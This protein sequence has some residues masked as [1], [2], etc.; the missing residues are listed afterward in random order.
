MRIRSRQKSNNTN[1]ELERG[2]RTV[3]E[4]YIRLAMAFN[5]VS[6]SMCDFSRRM[7]SSVFVSLT[8]SFSPPWLEVAMRM[9]HVYKRSGKWLYTESSS[10]WLASWLLTPAIS[11]S[12]SSLSSAIGIFSIMCSSSGFRMCSM[13]SKMGCRSHGSSRTCRKTVSFFSV[14]K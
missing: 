14:G 6:R 10:V 13:S 3:C 1:Q 8:F 12:R 7:W 2:K 11:N 5:T 9:E 4:S